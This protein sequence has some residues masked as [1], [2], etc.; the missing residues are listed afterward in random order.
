MI[1]MNYYD[2]HSF[3]ASAGLNT[4]STVIGNLCLEVYV[5][6]MHIIYTAACINVDVSVSIGVFVLK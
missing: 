2:I 5:G 3:S 1:F 6:V 4:K